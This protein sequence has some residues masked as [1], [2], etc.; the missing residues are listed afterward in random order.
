MGRSR[1]TCYHC[2]TS[3]P[4]NREAR[5]RHYTGTNHQRRVRQH[6]AQFA[7]VKERYHAEMAREVCRNYRN[8]GYCHFGVSCRNSHLQEAELLSLKRQAKQ[9]EFLDEYGPPPPPLLE[10]TDAA[11]VAAFLADMQQ[12]SLTGSSL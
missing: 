12:V 9:E 4:Y 3:F 6:Y 5:I 8:K 11:A 7:S 2:D 1:Y 10:K